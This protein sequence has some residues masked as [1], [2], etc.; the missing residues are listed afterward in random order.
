LTDS[1]KARIDK[2][3]NKED[4]EKVVKDMMKEKDDADRLE[5]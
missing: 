1:E 4:L 5:E 2:A 3:A